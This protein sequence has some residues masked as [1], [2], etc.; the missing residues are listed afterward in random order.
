MSQPD[1][2]VE[3][4]PRGDVRL[5]VG[6]A[7]DS[8]EVTTF[9][10]CSRTL[11]RA[12]PVF[13]RMLYG[14]FA[15]SKPQPPADGGEAANWVV[16]LPDDNARAMRTLLDITHGHFSAVP[17]ALSVGELYDLTVLTHYYDATRSLA[18][19]AGAWAARVEGA[20]AD[21]GAPAPKVLWIAWELGRGETFAGVARQMLME[22]EGPCL[23][24]SPELLGVQTPPD[25]IGKFLTIPNIPCAVVTSDE[26]LI[27]CRRN[28]S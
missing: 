22:S 8:A 18:P 17:A 12:S 28:Q 16:D 3:I 21:D 2:E 13:D 11:A 5:R 25:I 20:A 24:G 4:D 14:S 9:R 23:K 27:S 15:E 1:S 10:A 7:A 26:S 6:G 19:W